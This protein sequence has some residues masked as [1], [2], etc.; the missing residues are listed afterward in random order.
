[1]RGRSLKFQ[2]PTLEKV[3]QKEGKKSREK[4]DVLISTDKYQLFEKNIKKKKISHNEK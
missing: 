2:I 1:M 4:V 3:R